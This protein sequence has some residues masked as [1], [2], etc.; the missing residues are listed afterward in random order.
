MYIYRIYTYH[1][2]IVN[3]YITQYMEAMRT[4]SSQMKR[5]TKSTPA[6]TSTLALMLDGIVP[7]KAGIG[8]TIITGTIIPAAAGLAGS[9]T[10]SQV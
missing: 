7:A 3:M 1:I 8:G 4:G 9:N 10:N 6:P 2:Y 5:P